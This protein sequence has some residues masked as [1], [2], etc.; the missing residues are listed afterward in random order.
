MEIQFKRL[1]GGAWTKD[2][3]AMFRLRYRVFVERLKWEL[4]AT[5]SVETDSY[6]T[7]RTHYLVAFQQDIC[8]GCWRLLCT[9][10][11]YM[12][13]DEFDALLGGKEAPCDPL[14]WELSRFAIASDRQNA[15]GFADATRQLFSEVDRFAVDYDIKRYVTV[16]TVGV[17]RMLRH[18]GIS[19]DR[20]STPQLLG[21]SPAVAVS[22]S[23]SDF[24]RAGAAVQRNTSMAETRISSAV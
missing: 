24:G 17:E 13:R 9:T 2:H 16:T 4:P 14:I 1:S 18:A 5:T 15:F 3:E 19:C 8:V 6:D 23:P 12:L 21:G 22:M 7:E 10:G 11:P 20:F